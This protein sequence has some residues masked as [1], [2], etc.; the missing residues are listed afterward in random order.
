MQVCTDVCHLHRQKLEYYQGDYNTF[1]AV[2]A[3]QRERQQKLFEI[4]EAKKKE[5]QKFVDK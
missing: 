5:L 4:Q 2:R 1:E 3:E